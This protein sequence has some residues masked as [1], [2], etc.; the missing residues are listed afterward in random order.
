MEAPRL[1]LLDLNEDVLFVI[2]SFLSAK[3]ALKLSTTARGI[4]H[5]AKRHGLSEVTLLSPAHIAKVAA[6]MLADVPNRLLYLRKLEL[7]DG[8]LYLTNF[9][10]EFSPEHVH[11]CLADL[12]EQARGLKLLIL[13][14]IDNLLSAE[15]RIGTAFA[16]IPRLH[17]LELSGVGY[18]TLM[19]LS[20]MT[21]P[22]KTLILRAVE[23]LQAEQS[24][25]LT[26]LANLQGVRTINIVGLWIKPRTSNDP[27]SATILG[28]PA[29][30]PL[31]SEKTSS[32]RRLEVHNTLVPLPAFVR[33]FPRVREL[34]LSGPCPPAGDDSH[35]RWADMD[36]VNAHF[37]AQESWK[38]VISS[39]HHLELSHPIRR[40]DP[41]GPPRDLL[42]KQA[43]RMLRDV[44]P[45]RLTFSIDVGVSNQFWVDLLSCVPRLRVL[46][47]TLDHPLYHDMMLDVIEPWI[48][49]VP[50]ILKNL[51]VAYIHIDTGVTKHL[52]EDGSTTASG[53]EKDVTD[54]LPTLFVGNIDSLKLFSVGFK[55][56]GKHQDGQRV[57]S[58]SRKHLS[59]W[60]ATGQGADRVVRQISAA[61]GE[62]IRAY[63]Y[64]LKSDDT[65]DFDD[66]R[67]NDIM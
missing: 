28:R 39:V 2:V 61:A 50:P 46:E 4:H 41:P 10:G 47:V 49:D 14:D 32:V 17:R 9:Y 36:Y 58:M 21:R 29:I 66:T 1:T 11:R 8:L 64:T 31:P 48:C 34:V 12:L 24:G 45:V 7:V 33:A 63:L 23:E 6:Y 52:N 15:P 22:P 35:I 27:A 16:S 30:S 42:H 55:I 60:R 40:S 43:L 44:S 3:D 20:N 19:A 67:F 54:I 25:T 62:R 65:W 59:W 38:N 13:P 53:S 51:R 56:K 37:A 26:W 5:I 18:P 57:D